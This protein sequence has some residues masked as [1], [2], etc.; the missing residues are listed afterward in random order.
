M[1][2]R[3]A[4]Q[5]LARQ[6][7]SDCDLRCFI[8]FPRKDVAVV[9]CEGEPEGDRYRLSEVYLLSYFVVR[10]M[11][12]IP[13]Q[14]GTASADA[15]IRKVR[16]AVDR[17]GLSPRLSGGLAV[18]RGSAEKERVRFHMRLRIQSGRLRFDDGWRGMGFFDRFLQDYILPSTLALPVWLADTR[19]NDPDFLQ[20]AGRAFTNC[21]GEYS[22]HMTFQVV[23][24]V[25]HRSVQQAWQEFI[26]SQVDS[27]T[28][29]PP[30]PR[31]CGP[32]TSEKRTFYVVGETWQG[33][34]VAKLFCA[35]SE[36]RTRPDGIMMYDAP[37]TPGG[38][39]LIPGRTYMVF[40]TIEDAMRVFAVLN[41]DLPPTHGR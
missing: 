8:G 36:L 22:P 30:H 10:Q 18:Q 4:A 5:E 25:V 35:R 9:E 23:D 33:P 13:I 3:P 15:W 38:S 27:D 32:E 26:Q 11:L 16:D 37:P 7:P 24:A 17:D 20:L 19:G 6:V 28:H 1:S 12:V 14:I 21:L 2:T 40:E 39:A 29:S 31:P 34:K 41:G